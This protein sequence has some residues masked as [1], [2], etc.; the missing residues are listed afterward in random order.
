[1]FGKMVQ[2]QVQL[3]AP[4]PGLGLVYLGND[5]RPCLQLT[6][7]PWTK[8]I[9]NNLQTK[10]TK[11]G[12]VLWVCRKCPCCICYQGLYEPYLGWPFMKVLDFRLKNCFRSV[13]R[14]ARAK[15]VMGPPRPFTERTGSLSKNSWKLRPG[16][17]P[18]TRPNLSQN[19]KTWY[20]YQHAHI[21]VYVSVYKVMKSPFH[22][23]S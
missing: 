13:P 14:W 16:K 20:Q 2:D 21:H 1:M 8:F 12:F 6:G 19:F 15:T 11:P 22:F 4:C 7:K 23:F 5:N 18:E 9:P 3:D 10:D 17:A